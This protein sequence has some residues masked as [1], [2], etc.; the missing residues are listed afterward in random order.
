KGGKQICLRF[1]SAQ[2]CRGKNGKCIIDNLCH[3]KPAALPDVVRD[4]TDKNY[5]GLSS[6]MQ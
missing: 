5:G 6:D 2:G 1:L 3:F 4:F